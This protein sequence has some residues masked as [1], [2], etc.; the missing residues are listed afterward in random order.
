MS[1]PLGVRLLQEADGLSR[2]LPNGKISV[3]RRG[4]ECLQARFGSRAESATRGRGL[5]ADG[6]VSMLEERTQSPQGRGVGFL[7][8]GHRFKGGH[9]D[10]GVFIPFR[11]LEEE[12]FG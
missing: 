11:S 5:D 3:L 10:V 1:S 2:S 6:G 8:P 12:R 9:A 4:L 7:L